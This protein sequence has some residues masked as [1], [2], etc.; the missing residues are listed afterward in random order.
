MFAPGVEGEWCKWMVLAT[1]VF[2]LAGLSIANTVLVT[3]FDL[4]QNPF[5]TLSTFLQ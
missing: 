3:V 5:A 2:R 1:Y 4:N